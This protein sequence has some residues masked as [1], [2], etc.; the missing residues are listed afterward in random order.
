MRALLISSYFSIFLQPCTYG[1]AQIDQVMVNGFILLIKFKYFS[2]SFIIAVTDDMDFVTEQVININVIDNDN[3]GDTILNYIDNCVEVENIIKNN[4]DNDS[5]GDVCDIDIDGDG[6]SNV[7]EQ[8]FGG[9]PLDESD[10][11][12]VMEAIESF[13]IS[14]QPLNRPVPAIGDLGLI[15][16]GISILSL[17]VKRYRRNW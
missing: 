15:I 7:I 11:N 10:F 8:E 13:S 4:L 6:F 3:D 5:F 1:Q 14:D 17:G 16:L 9:D 12:T 2:D